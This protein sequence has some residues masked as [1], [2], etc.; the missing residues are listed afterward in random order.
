MKLVIKSAVR[1]DLRDIADY[2]ARDNPQRA[3]TFAAELSAKIKDLAER[4]YSF[5]E[6]EE[7]TAGLR[8]ALFHKYHIIFTIDGDAVVVLRI[9]HGARNIVD[10]V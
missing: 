4:P 7:W 1:M 2:F 6:H 10:I 9:L 3:R 5:P 8:S